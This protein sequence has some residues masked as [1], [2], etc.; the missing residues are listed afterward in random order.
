ML[1]RGPPGSRCAASIARRLPS[2][3]APPGLLI[4]EYSSWSIITRVHPQ[5]KVVLG[6]GPVAEPHAGSTASQ[7]GS[8]AKRQKE[9]RNGGANGWRDR[10]IG[11]LAHRQAL[12][13]IGALVTGGDEANNARRDLHV[14]CPAESPGR[15]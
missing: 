1:V 7:I 9:F 2:F 12:I 11:K 6:E 10:P 4:I 15:G 3:R 13:Q 8:P 14:A 5:V